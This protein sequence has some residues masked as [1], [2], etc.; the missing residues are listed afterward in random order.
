MTQGHREEPSPLA[1]RHAADYDSAGLISLIGGCFAEYPGC[2]LDLP[3]ID[4]WMLAPA[5]AYNAGGRL[6]VVEL[7]RDI[8]A[9]DGDIVARDGDTVARDGELVACVGYKRSGRGRAELKSLYVAAAARRSGLGARLVGVVEDAARSAGAG[10]VELWS[11][12]RFVDAHRLY[13]RLGYRRGTHTRH[14]HDPSDSTEFFFDK[15][16]A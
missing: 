2:V 7:D 15:P 1:V 6:W 8:V 14:L 13:E 16:L 3:G 9:R 5:S 4:A 11:D 12:T 10:V